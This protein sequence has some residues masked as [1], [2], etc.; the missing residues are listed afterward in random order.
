MYFDFWQLVLIGAVIAVLI[1]LLVLLLILRPSKEE[2][3][4]EEKILRIAYSRVVEYLLARQTPKAV[5]VLLNITKRDL[6]DIN[7]YILL[8]KLFYSIGETKRGI[9]LLENLLLRPALDRELRVKVLVELSLLYKSLGKIAK[10]KD[11]LE[12][13]IHLS[14]NWETPYRRI[15]E[16]L[17]D[18]QEFKQAHKMLAKWERLAGE[19]ATE[20][21]GSMWLKEG[22]I[23]LAE[24]EL[25]EAKKILAKARKK[26]PDSAYV[27]LLSARV[28]AAENDY[29]KLMES[30]ANAASNRRAAADVPAIMSNILKELDSDSLSEETRENL[31]MRIA[32][33]LANRNYSSRHEVEFAALFASVCLFSCSV[34]ERFGKQ[35]QQAISAV[36]KW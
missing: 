33:A 36:L 15:A 20:L 21:H 3:G 4:S 35:A 7:A 24:G 13:A 11:L 30:L 29:D 19:T 12:E 26:L 8:A 31:Y 16:V 25:K 6:E 2:D 23:F 17:A 9:D 5:D 1:L 32:E 34:S 22:E 28:A 10:A 27:A 14:S 18:A